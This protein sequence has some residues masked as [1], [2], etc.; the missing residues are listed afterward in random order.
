MR[1]TILI[2]AAAAALCAQSFDVASIHAHDPR[3]ARFLV[4]PPN[5]GTFTA[6]GAVAKL[7]VMLA[8]DVQ[9]S[10]ISGG[11]DWLATE[12]WDIEAKSADTNHDGAATARLLRGM[13][14]E[15]FALKARWVEEARPVYLLTLA[16]GGAKLR[17]SE[18]GNTNLQVGANSIS[19]RRGSVADLAKVLA[20]ALGRPVIDRTGLS[21]SYDL[22]VQWDDAPVREGGVPGIE[23]AT[24][25]GNDRGSIFSAVQ[26]QLGLRLESGR[27][28]VD[29]LVIDG[30]ERP[31]AN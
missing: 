16:R 12:K 22:F 19:L 20:T 5:R 18:E 14:E 28:P 6:V 10:Q 27:A 26:E 25:A 29:V 8:Y 11:P 4:R 15:R 9:D 1:R 13:L 17:E 24:T 3:D 7:L 30:M 2:C 21:G 31:T 23:A